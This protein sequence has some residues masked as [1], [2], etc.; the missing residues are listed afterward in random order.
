M[1]VTHTVSQKLENVIIT[2]NRWITVER[3]LKMFSYLVM[4]MH[5]CMRNN[6]IHDFKFM[7]R[8]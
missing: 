5:R 2:T 7:Y 1:N 3:T 4:H 6:K 8:K